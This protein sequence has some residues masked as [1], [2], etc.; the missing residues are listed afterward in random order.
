M[1][2]YVPTMSLQ[3]PDNVPTKNG[4][5]MGVP[6]IPTRITRLHAHAPARTSDPLLI[7]G[8]TVGTP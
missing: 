6:T 5:V 7:S 2:T 3:S 4:L 8:G 1:I